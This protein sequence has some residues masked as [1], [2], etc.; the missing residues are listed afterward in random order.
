MSDELDDACDAVC[1]GT[2]GEDFLVM[3]GCPGCHYVSGAAVAFGLM[4]MAEAIRTRPRYTWKLVVWFCGSKNSSLSWHDS[5]A[6]AEASAS[7]QIAMGHSSG[8][9]PPQITRIEHRHVEDWDDRS[10]DR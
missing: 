10:E 6:E 5:E 7:R 1:H 2:N 9:R 4:G 3:S 8:S